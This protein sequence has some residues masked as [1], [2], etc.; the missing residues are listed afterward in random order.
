MAKKCSAKGIIN[1]LLAMHQRNQRLD[2]L[3]NTEVPVLIIAGNNDTIVP[4]DTLSY[5]ASL[6]Q[7]CKFVLFTESAHMGMLEE[8]KK[9]IEVLEQFMQWLHPTV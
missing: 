4:V 3:K 5:Q 9:S 1:A 8:P 2:V 6:P 7:Q